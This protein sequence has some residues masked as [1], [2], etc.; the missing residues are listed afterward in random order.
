[1]NETP[2]IFNAGITSVNPVM[3]AQFKKAG[4]SI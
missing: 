3:V 4:I 1:M 2:L